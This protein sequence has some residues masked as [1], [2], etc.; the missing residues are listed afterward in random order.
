METRQRIDRRRFLKGSGGAIAGTALGGC[1]TGGDDSIT[2]GW[3][4]PL[5]GQN[6]GIGEQ[7]RLGAKL[8]TEQVN[9]AGGLDGR[10]VDS[11]HED[12]QSDPQTGKQKARKL[13]DSE[14]VDL[15]AGGFSSSVVLSI[16]PY[17]DEQNVPF[18]SS[19][20][21]GSITREECRRTT[22]NVVKRTNQAANT[23]VPWSVEEL[24]GDFWLHY[25]DYVWGQS[26][27]DAVSSVAEDVDGATLLDVTKTGSGTSDFG[28]YVSQIAS[29]DAEWVY[30]QLLGSDAVN[31]VKQADNYGLTDDVDLV[32]AGANSTK[33]FRNGAGDAALGNYTLVKY[34]EAHDSEANRSFVSDF[35]EKHKAA[36]SLLSWGTWVSGNMYREAVEAAGSTDTDDVVSTLPEVEFDTGMGTGSFRECDNLLALPSFVGEYVPDDVEPYPGF[37]VRQKYEPEEVMLSCEEAGCSK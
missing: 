7:Q 8:F 17:A 36:P 29:S 13:I 18:I 24:G 35:R 37:D 4:H 6:A 5:S 14:G 22:F 19:G 21:A 30:L 23:M 10:D 33:L 31:F 16:M 28:S 27:R 15:L 34:D 12:T 3:V 2:I 20:A 25:Q 11:V 9:D 32:L 26:G 1:L